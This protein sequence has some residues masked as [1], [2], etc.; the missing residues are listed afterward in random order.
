MTALLLFVVLVSGCQFFSGSFESVSV[1]D[2]SGKSAQ[3]IQAYQDYLKKYPMTSLGPRIYYR[4][5]KNYEAQSDYTNAIKW[6]EKILGEY[7]HTDEELHALLDL[8]DL[9]QDKLKNPVK[10]M[11]YNQRAFS[12]YMDNIQIRDAIQ[13]MIDAQ[14][15]TATAQFSQKNY[16]GTDDALDVIAKTYPPVFIQPDTR[17]KIDSLADLSRRAQ[18]I[19]KAGVDWIVLK[20]EI[21]FNKSYE[22]DFLPP[23]QDDQ[24]MQSPDG[25]YLAERK[26]APNGN[27]YL[28]V[29]KISSQSDK[30]T[31]NLIPQTIGAELPAWSPDGRDL[32]Y[33]Q[34]GRKIRKLQK[35]NVQ[36]RITQT[37][38]FTRSNSLGIHP[39]YHPAGNK[40][41]YIYEGRV[42]LVN[43]GDTSYK[44]L[45][46]TSQKLDYT[47]DLAWSMD[48]TM[49]RC[50]QTDK[51]G[52]L[53][54]ELLVLDISAPTNP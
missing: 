16:K 25:D 4:L 12:R 48:G 28:Y 49:I 52:K 20:N 1:L 24:V 31:F 13:S 53:M 54:D 14:Y 38:F 40:I 36:S 18:G 47:A 26:R 35:T 27:Y 45:L 44:Q 23:V 7:P 17:A 50:H 6:Y 37:L 21:P 32:V 2:Q 11:E 10:T 30:A 22:Q 46:K 43:T 51:S 9:Y 8:A 15:L 3:A 34:T 19:A 42:C 5:A 29:A 41:A 33:W 39:A